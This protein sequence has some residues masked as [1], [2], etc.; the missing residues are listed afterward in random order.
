[1]NKSKSFTELIVWQKAHKL[2]LNIYKLTKSFPKEELY[3][4]TSQMRR[5]AIS[6][7]A[8]IAEGYKKKTPKDKLRFFNV[9]EGFL[10]ELKYYLILARDLKYCKIDDL[11]DPTN[12]V[13]K[14]ISGYTNSIKKNN[15][16]S[17][18]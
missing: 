8:N 17:I 3:S 16:N 18:S 1:M 15:E 6:I 2:V 4:L 9:A 12:E 14:L 10:E 13:G 11:I 7:P 5:S